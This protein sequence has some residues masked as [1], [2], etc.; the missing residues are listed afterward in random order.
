MIF[1]F[2]IFVYLVMRI[3]GVYNRRILGSTQRILIFSMSFS[4]QQDLGNKR[5]LIGD[6]IRFFWGKYFWGNKIAL[7]ITFYDYWTPRCPI[8]RSYDNNLRQTILQKGSLF[9]I[10]TG[11]GDR[12]G[13]FCP[14]RIDQTFYLQI[15]TWSERLTTVLP[16]LKYTVRL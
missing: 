8:S 10:P 11:N 12:V 7:V 6:V 9:K 2:Y 4:S 14:A 1:H 5:S 3:Y 15:W 13:W 16:S